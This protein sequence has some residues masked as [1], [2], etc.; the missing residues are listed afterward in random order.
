[1]IPRPGAGGRAV[2]TWAGMWRATVSASAAHALGRGTV[3]VGSRAVMGAIAAMLLASSLHGADHD[4][5]GNASAQD[6]ASLDQRV[7]ELPRDGFGCRSQYIVVLGRR[8]KRSVLLD[9]ARWNDHGPLAAPH[10]IT[11][12]HPGHLADEDGV[13]SV[14]R[15]RAV[16]EAMC[17]VHTTLSICSSGLFVDTGS[18]S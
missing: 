13:E 6:D 7:A 15:T 1:M 4:P 11:H 12:L 16:A 14:D 2:L 5:A 17:G 18:S 3:G 8:H 10:R 9:A